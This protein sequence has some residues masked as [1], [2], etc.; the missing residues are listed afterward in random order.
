MFFKEKQPLMAEE[1]INELLKRK[2]I[3]GAR[4]EDSEELA[5][6]SIIEMDMLNEALQLHFKGSF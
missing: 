1:Q 4:L 5:K 2:A 6:T 3:V